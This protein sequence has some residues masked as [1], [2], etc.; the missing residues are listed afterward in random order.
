[1][2]TVKYFHNQLPGAPAMTGQAGSGIAVLDACLVNGFGLK[3]LD[4][5]AV[6]GGIATGTVS[7]GHS[8]EP[9]T[10]AEIVGATPTGLN[11]QKRILSVA[12]NTFTFDATGISNQTATGTITCRLAPAGW[13]KPFTGTNV[14]VYR[15]NNVA[16]T[17]MF[18]QVTDTNAVTRN[19]QMRG[20]E[21]MLDAVGVGQAAFPSALQVAGAGLFVAKSSTNDA[22]ARNWFLIADDRTFYL[23]TSGGSSNGG[24]VGFGDF[25]SVKAGDPFACMISAPTSDLITNTNPS[26]IDLSYSHSTA[27]GSIYAPRSFSGI[28]TSASLLQRAESYWNTNGWSGNTNNS[29]ANYPNQADNALL[30]N[31]LLVIEP[32]I[33]TLRGTQRGLLHS[34]QICQG[35]FNHRDKI[36]G[37]GAYAGRKLIFLSSNGAYAN[38]VKTAGLFFDITGPWD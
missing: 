31:R 3:T 33:P 19:F 14:A 34:P 5:L 28:G 16:G 17:R 6:S 1:M 24:T 23:W 20:F 8:F 36:D 4:T 13:S 30:L 37:R 2:S 32:G 12:G 35:F 11:G 25:A 38:G 15:S 18:L 22:V 10:I 29:L 9:D 27:P 7:T 26:A 21:N